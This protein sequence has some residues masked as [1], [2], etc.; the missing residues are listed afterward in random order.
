MNYPIH[1]V[2]YALTPRFYDREYLSKKAPGGFTRKSPNQDIEVIT[3]LMEAFDKISEDREEAELLRQQYAIFHQRKG[4]FATQAVQTDTV[5]MDAIDWWST[6]GSQVLELAE[7]AQKVIMNSDG[8]RF[9]C[10]DMNLDD[11]NYNTFPFDNHPLSSPFPFAS[12]EGFISGVNSSTFGENQ[13][14]DHFMNQG[15]NASGSGTKSAEIKRKRRPTKKC[16][17]TLF[18]EKS[19]NVLHQEKNLTGSGLNSVKVQRKRPPTKKGKKASG[20]QRSSRFRGVTRYPG[21]FEAFLWD[22]SD[23]QVKG[24]TVYIGGFREE[25]QA[26]RAHDLAALKYWGDSTPLNFPVSD[27]MKE[28]EEMQAYTKKDYL[29]HIRRT[30]ACFSKGLSKYRGVSKYSRGSSK[31]L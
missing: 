25:E 1:C 11:F 5:T 6:Y 24:K 9:L 3:S 26:A 27:Y 21:H 17:R 2:G 19:D 20:H 18:G 30:S 15:E 12:D 28:L 22:N 13:I 31:G 7:V 29:L 10:S 16:K 4:I 8:S 23:S 14:S